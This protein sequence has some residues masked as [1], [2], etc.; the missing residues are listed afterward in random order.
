MKRVRKKGCPFC[1]EEV[2]RCVVMVDFWWLLRVVC[3]E[4][5][6]SGPGVEKEKGQLAAWEKWNTRG[7]Q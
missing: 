5:G 2:G 7:K 4:C 1:R 3:L 6:A